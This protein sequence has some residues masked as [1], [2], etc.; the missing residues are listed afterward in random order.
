MIGQALRQVFSDGRYVLLA[1]VT[2]LATFVLATWFANLGLVWQIAISKPIP[3]TD[4]LAILVAL[5]GSIDTNFT[6]FSALST[7]AVAALTGANI[8]MMAY[9]FRLR[10]TRKEVTAASL[11]GLASGF[12]GIGCTACGTLVLSPALTF[13]G[14]GTLIAL[15]PFGGEE[16]GGLG[17]LML[18]LSL[19]LCARKIAL[20]NACQVP[21]RIRRSNLRRTDNVS[22]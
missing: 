6:G 16:F 10:Q 20:A 3:L 17:V 12:L 21:T 15:L 1:A 2:G 19:V 13:F 8:A 9:A 22:N 18:G 11:S 14:A 4:K 7:I 5:V